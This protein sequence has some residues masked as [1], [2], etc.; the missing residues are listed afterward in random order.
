MP[1]CAVRLS[2][3]SVTPLGV[4]WRP[5]WRFTL[6]STLGVI[7]LFAVLFTAALLWATRGHTADADTEE[8]DEA[9]PGKPS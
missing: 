4:D 8:Q 3:D 5:L 1:V 2:A 7:G 6:P 9:A